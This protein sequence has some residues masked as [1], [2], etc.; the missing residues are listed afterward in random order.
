MVPVKPK[1]MKVHVEG[2]MKKVAHHI[3][4]R[5]GKKLPERVIEEKMQILTVKP[6]V[7][8][9]TCKF[10]SESQQIEDLFNEDDDARVKETIH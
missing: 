9:C 7:D 2:K 5:R 3:V 10:V 6:K 8:G 4:L 1:V